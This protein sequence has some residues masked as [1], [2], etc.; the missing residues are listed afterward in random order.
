M[1]NNI[2]KV[3]EKIEALNLDGLLITN[4][5]NVKHLSGFTGDSST[6]LIS[7]NGSFLFTD[8][9]YI[10]QANNECHSNITPTLWFE[11]RRF[12]HETYQL[13]F[14]KAELKKIGFEKTNLT[15]DSY[16]RLNTNL[17]GISLV[18]TAG[19]VEELRLIKQEHEIKALR[20]ACE[21][22]DLALENTVKTIKEGQTEVE[23]AALLE[24]NMRLAGADNISFET[25]VLTGARTSLLHGKASNVPLKNGDYLLFDF[26]ALVDGFHADMSRTFIIGTPDDKH[27]ELYQIIQN[28]QQAIVDNVSDGVHISVINQLID[29]IIPEEYKPYFYAGYGHG[30]GL[31]IHE[32]PFMRHDADFTYQKNMVVTI[33]PGIYI[34]NWGGLRIED[35][36]LVTTNGAETLTQFDKNMICL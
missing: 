3:I 10:E 30:V 33:E 4:E 17:K 7:Q 15:F 31:D 22:S 32:Q 2:T 12:G 11:D 28:C 16:D 20:K 36:I 6:L 19:I 35:T 29:E 9:R 14:D 18:P 23:I 24:Y 5:T 25:M 13:A 8:P 34:P 27:K 21:L 26:G 1:A